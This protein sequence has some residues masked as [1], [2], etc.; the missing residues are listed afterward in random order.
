MIPDTQDVPWTWI[1]KAYKMKRLI[2]AES[3]QPRMKDLGLV[4]YS[5]PLQAETDIRSTEGTGH[6]V[7][8]WKVAAPMSS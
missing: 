1:S 2:F 8:K 7:C 3:P 4:N 6:I 5:T